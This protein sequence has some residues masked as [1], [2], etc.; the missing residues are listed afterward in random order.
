MPPS[1]P[2][3]PKP[4]QPKNWGGLAKLSG[5][6]TAVGTAK[7]HARNDERNIEE[8]RCGFSIK[9]APPRC[10]PS[11]TPPLFSL[12]HPSPIPPI[13]DFF[14]DSSPLG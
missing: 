10:S 1:I 7:G 2:P 14:T 12:S 11:H 9:R 3:K 8:L 13:T 6:W 4:W 5:C